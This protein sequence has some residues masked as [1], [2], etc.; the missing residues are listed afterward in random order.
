[1]DAQRGDVF[2]A[3]I[4]RASRAELEPPVAAH[5][6]AVLQQWRGGLLGKRVAFVGDAV[7]RDRDLIAQAGGGRWQTQAPAALAPQIARLGRR[8]AEQGFAGLPH[9]LTPV[10]VRR[11]DAEIEKENRARAAQSRDGQN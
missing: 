4:E 3:V 10:Y 8:L 1:M 2:A 7:T 6:S 5:P 9:A 11:P